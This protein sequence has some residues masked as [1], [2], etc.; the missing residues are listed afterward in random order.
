MI[1]PD[2]IAGKRPSYFSSSRG[3]VSPDVLRHP[4][5]LCRFYRDFYLWDRLGEVIR[6]VT[7]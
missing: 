6:L 3:S 4:C 5:V 2:Q 1:P 7:G